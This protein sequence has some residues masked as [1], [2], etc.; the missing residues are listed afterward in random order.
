MQTQAWVNMTISHVGFHRV[1]MHMCGFDPHASGNLPGPAKGATHSLER[2]KR[3][4]RSPNPT[5]PA[6]ARERD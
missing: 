6:R 3:F 2:R 1:L 5:I 4:R